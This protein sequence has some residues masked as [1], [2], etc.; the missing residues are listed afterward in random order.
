MRATVV[1]GGGVGGVARG[2]GCG[3]RGRVARLRGRPRSLA[4]PE[5]LDGEVL[6]DP[7]LDLVEIVVVF[8][9][10]A[11][12]LDGIEAILGRLVPRDVQHPV[13]VGA[14]HLVFRR[15]RGH[16]LEAVDF[17]HRNR[18]DPLGQVRVGDPRADF[19]DLAVAFSELGLD[20]LQLLPQHVLPLGVGH[21]LLGARFDAALHLED[22]DLARQ[23]RGDRVELHLE[24]VRLEKQL[25][26]LRLHVEQAG[27]E[28]GDAQRVVH[29]GDE[30]FDV[31]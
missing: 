8:V 16:A 2:R 20:R 27:Q 1:T 12:R 24:V 19:L 15:R 14:D 4:L 6:D 28:V 26:V 25:L 18:L 5:L 31:G 10:H 22:L 30:R 29:A 23:R 3:G 21:L 13:D 11:T 9:E 7:L 17:P